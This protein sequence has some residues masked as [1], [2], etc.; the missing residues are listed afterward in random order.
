MSQLHVA[1]R[2][3]LE[4]VRTTKGIERIVV[5]HSLAAAAAAVA[6]GWIPG[7]G[8]VIATGI[9]MGFTLTMYINIC[10]AC[11]FT[12]HKNILKS[13]ASVAIAEIVAYL[14]VALVVETVITFFPG[15]NIGAAV[16]AGVINFAMVYIAGVLF[17]KMMANVFKA[18]KKIDSIS[19]NE[20][21]DFMKKEATRE[22]IS[23]VY[24][25]AK[26]AYKETKD[27]KTYKTEDIR[28]TE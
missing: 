15:L 24:E 22:N 5:T 13:I 18:N 12:L 17:L 6:S 1:A 9:A 3:I 7:A 4:Y 23:S 25:E 2:L 16:I 28:P 26:N 10:K 8:G 14:A 11:N 27:D 21:E 19:S 20:W